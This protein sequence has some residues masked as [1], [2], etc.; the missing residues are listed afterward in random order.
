M[1]PPRPSGS[2]PEAGRL[3]K[4]GTG[5]PPLGARASS[6]ASWGVPIGGWGMHGPPSPYGLRA[7]GRAHLQVWNWQPPPPLG[8]RASRPHLLPSDVPWL[9]LRRR[10]SRSRDRRSQGAAARNVRQKATRRITDGDGDLSPIVAIYRML[11]HS[12]SRFVFLCLLS[13]FFG[14]FSGRNRVFLP[15][16]R[17]HRRNTGIYGSSWKHRKFFTKSKLAP[18]QALSSSL[19]LSSSLFSLPSPA[20]VSFQTPARRNVGRAFFVSALDA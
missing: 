3:A 14:V 7:R 20:G 2:T 19:L 8:A 11:C 12:S 1:V 17:E 18:R 4:R 10:K 13:A 15:K 6:P 9:A 5:R 16:S